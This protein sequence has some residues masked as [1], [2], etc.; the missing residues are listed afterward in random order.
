M[1]TTL[2][3]MPKKKPAADRH[4]PRRMVGVPERIC[5][6]FESLTE[7]RQASL[8]ELVKIACLDWLE[9][10]GAWPPKKSGRD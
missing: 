4:K 3:D 1:V 6:A 2:V 7:Q 9:R 10:Q 8:S 5:A